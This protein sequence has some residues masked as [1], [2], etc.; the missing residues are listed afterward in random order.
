MLLLPNFKTNIHKLSGEIKENVR[1]LAIAQI[2]YLYGGINLPISFLCVKNLFD[3][4]V[5]NTINNKMFICEKYDNS[6]MSTQQEIKTQYIPDVTFYGAGPKCNMVNEYIMHLQQKI[7][8][9]NQTINLF[10]NDE[11][12]WLVTDVINKCNIINRQYIGVADI[13]NNRITVD[14]LLSNN[15]LLFIDDLYGIYIPSDDIL[16]RHKYGWFA[17]MSY[18]QIFESKLILCKLIN[19]I[20]NN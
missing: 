19:L 6:V 16:K 7:S 8:H 18:T 1:K 11:Y 2:I 14:N 5:K 12:K 17:R 4:Y 15:S 3:L 13:K 10:N 20:I 9:M